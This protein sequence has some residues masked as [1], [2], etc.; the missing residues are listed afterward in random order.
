MRTVLLCSK[1]KQRTLPLHYRFYISKETTKASLKKVH[2][3]EPFELLNSVKEK[4]ERSPQRTSKFLFG[5]SGRKSS[6]PSGSSAPPA[7]RMKDEQGKGEV[8]TPSKPFT[9]KIESL[10][11]STADSDSKPWC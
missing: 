9:M 4:K 8:S 5:E 1:K 3:E 2:F 7:N 6:A 11:V 10:L